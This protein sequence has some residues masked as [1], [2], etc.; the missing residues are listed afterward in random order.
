MRTLGSR[1]CRHISSWELP[2]D[3]GP[4]LCP[5]WKHLGLL[6]LR[7]IELFQL[8]HW[9]WSQCDLL[10]LRAETILGPLW[11]G[12]LLPGSCL[13]SLI[14]SPTTPGL[15]WAL[16]LS[17]PSSAGHCPSPAGHCPSPH[18][19]PEPLSSGSP[20]EWR[21]DVLLSPGKFPPH[22]RVA[23]PSTWYPYPRHVV[24]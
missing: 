20:V 16:T 11:Q 10:M 22:P 21:W 4:R 17:L 15:S 18:P 24:V 19:S 13:S 8:F 12:C 23:G 5:G 3:R 14:F 9:Q 2:R 7:T 1:G 6:Q